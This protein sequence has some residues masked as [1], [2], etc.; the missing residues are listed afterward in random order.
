VTKL[1]QDRN[2]LAAVLLCGLALLGAVQMRG[3]GDGQRPEAPVMPGQDLTEAG[4]RSAGNVRVTEVNDY[5]FGGYRGDFPSPPHADLNPRKAFIISWKE[6]PYR[7]VFSHEASYCPWFEMPSG[8]AV[9]FQFLEGNEGWAELFNEQ[10]RKERNSFVEVIEWGP[11]RVW[12]RWTY[13]GV[14]LESGRAA[15]RAVEDFWAF[16]NRLILRRQTFHSLIPGENIGY[17]REPI[18]II[19]ICPVG[20]LW[21]DILEAVPATG[22]NRAFV[23]LDPFSK[24][25]VD[26]LWKH[27][28]DLIEQGKRDSLAKQRPFYYGTAR[29]IGSEWTELDNARGVAALTPL[30]DGTPFV[31]FGDASGFPHGLTR[32]KEHFDRSTGGWGWGTHS[33]DH[34]PIGWLN[35]QAHDVDE[36]SFKLYPNH[37]APFGVDLWEMPNEQAEGTPFYSLLGV[38]GNDPEKVRALARE[39]L[40]GNRVTNPENVAALRWAGG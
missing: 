39:W 24:A 7:F 11:G 17:A 3:I 18:E 33:W 32:I 4:D 20:K 22:E 28:P 25:R 1:V 27:R 26:I 35:S 10:G 21:Y 15:Y 30:R 6:R 14:N 19:P 5:V 9:S 12:V 40:G 16:P 38:A 34:W 8:A 29:R 37:F 36:N 13:F 31:I 23:G 2:G